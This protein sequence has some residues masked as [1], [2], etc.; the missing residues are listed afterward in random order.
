LTDLNTL[1]P[2]SS[3]LYLLLAYAI[4]SS[5][6]IVGL[7][8]TSAG[9]LHG[10]VATPSNL[11]SSGGAPSTGTTAVVTP[12]NLTTSASS[13]VLDGSASTSSSGNLSYL[14]NVVPGGKQAAL[15]QTSTSPKATVDFVNGAGLYLIQLTVTDASG[16]SAK[17]PVVMLNYQV[18]STTSAS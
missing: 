2:T 16:N 9:E 8:V 3:T 18:S 14:F 12:L 6:Q 1:I 7:A 10:F 13:V 5:G 11:S 17:S 15:L 4:N